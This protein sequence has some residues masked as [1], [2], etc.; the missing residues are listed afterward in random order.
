MSKIKT[1][2]NAV[3][4][5][6]AIGWIMMIGLIS[7]IIFMLPGKASAHTRW[8]P[9][10]DLAAM[11]DDNILF[12]GT[13][14]IDDY[15][16]T[17]HPQLKLEY[18][19]EVT[20]IHSN[21]GVIFRRYQD[22]DQFN[23]E[24]YNFDI[25]AGTNLSERFRLG[26]F[27]RF[28]KDT[29]LDSELKETGRIFTREDRMS[30]SAGLSPTFNLSERTSIGLDG[31]YRNVTYDSHNFVDYA[32]WDVSLPV[33]WKLRTQIDSVYLSPG[34]SDNDSDTTHSKSYNFRIGWTHKATERLNLDMSL[35]PRYTELERLST[36]ETD[37][38]WNG[39]GI[40][41][42]GYTFETGL[43]TIDFR[44]G[45][46]SS[47]SGDQVDVSRVLTTLRWDF[48]ERVGTELNGSY[49]YTK[50][51]GKNI[52]DS[53]EYLQAGAELFYHVTENHILFVAYEF[54][55]EK[56][57]NTTESTPRAERNQVLAGIRLNFPIE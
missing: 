1:A 20:Q 44:R 37:K 17:I 36:G 15:V 45:L 43:L 18:D 13:E 55:Q 16:Y 23:D 24:I 46:E 29:T 12:G 56:L 28:I 21:G 31:G 49:Y 35:G 42:M 57:K 4:K 2:P 48:A 8:T 33:R 6:R 53:T 30:H 25:N 27:Y 34:Y 50:T 3:G 54:S 14:T 5:R 19:Q 51:E 52:D 47:A 22:N 39:V 9:S 38:S 41:K 11:Y 10:V 7:Q 26:S 32:A 40:L